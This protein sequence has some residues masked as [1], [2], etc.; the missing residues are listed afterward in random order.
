MIV[1]VYNISD[2]HWIKAGTHTVV[3]CFGFCSFE[4]S[5]ILREISIREVLNDA[6]CIDKDT[7]MLQVVELGS[8]CD[9]SP[10]HFIR[11]QNKF[12]A[13]SLLGQV[14]VAP[15]GSHTYCVWRG[16]DSPEQ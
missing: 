15:T 13:G 6:S 11:L 2:L 9:E 8:A 16:F 10:Q 4:S 5:G 12:G 14:D 1:V 7:A 3:P